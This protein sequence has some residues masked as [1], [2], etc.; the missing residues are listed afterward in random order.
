MEQKLFISAAEVAKLL[1]ISQSKS[2][3][4]CKSLN[5][6][7]RKQGYITIAGKVNTKYFEEKIYGGRTNGCI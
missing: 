5:D 2:Y 6:Q 7:L 1:G 4:I 3:Q